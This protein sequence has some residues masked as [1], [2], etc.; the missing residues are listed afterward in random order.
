M[1]NV[2]NHYYTG[3]IAAGKKNN[4]FQA[5]F[6]TG[7]TNLWL[8]SKKCK[9]KGCTKHKQYDNSTSNSYK[10]IGEP[11]HITFGSGTLDGEINEETFWLCG[12]KAKNQHFNEAFHTDG[13][14]FKNSNFDSIV[15][16]AF[17]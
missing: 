3:P 9:E 13:A 6:D 4:Y 14:I 10:Y 17:P 16:L 1:L 8:F 2:G 12:E 15:G 5:I 7:S 11:V